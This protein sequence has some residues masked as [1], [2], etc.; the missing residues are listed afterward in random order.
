MR[1]KSQLKTISALAIIVLIVFISFFIV[2]ANRYKTAKSVLNLADEIQIKYFEGVTL[3]DQYI[4]YREDRPKEQWISVNQK[5]DKLLQELEKVKGADE[6]LKELTLSKMKGT[7]LF[8]RIIQNT[9]FLKTNP[10]NKLIYSEFDNRL[11]SQIYI[12]YN[13]FFNGIREIRFQ[14][15]KEVEIT[16]RN[17]IIAITGLTVVLSLIV[18]FI[19]W[20]LRGI[21]T[22][23]LELLHAG[24]DIISQG[25]LDYRIKI[26][27]EDEFSDLASSFNSMTNKL[28]L[29]N[30]Q[31]EL[32]RA[33]SV[34]NAKLASLGEMSASIAHEINNPLSVIQLTNSRLLEKLKTDPLST[35]YI[36]HSLEKIQ[37]AVDRINK[38][39]KGLTNLSRNAA[40]EDIQVFSVENMME[41][42]L[43]LVGQKLKYSNVDLRVSIPPG[44]LFIESS[45][46]Q[47]SQV[48]INLINNA[49]DA[50]APRKDKWIKVDF[51]LVKDS[52]IV[53]CSVTDSGEGIPS[54]IAEK[55]MQPFFTTKEVGKGTGLGLS[56]SKEIIE[57]LGGTFYIDKECSNTCFVFEL[58]KVFKR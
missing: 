9:S 32:E 43:S 36:V 18:I 11:I 57:T 26:E 6:N 56:I 14:T 53:R 55:I 16:Y 7:A 1:I 19:S 21:I 23:R 3:R 54:E 52:S 13:E 25:K 38:I 20:H 28:Q 35:E 30:E 47:I 51:K 17:L 15:E 22:R 10:P 34:Q 12:R 46:T 44:D 4:L 8:N 42:V 37:G 39:I 29:N 50:I 49:N 31:L 5:L 41:Q 45:L 2:A 58:P 27:G 33:R 24:A 40:N 48:L